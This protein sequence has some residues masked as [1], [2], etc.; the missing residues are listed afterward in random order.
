LTQSQSYFQRALTIYEKIDRDSLEV[1]SFHTNLGNVAVARGDL[2]KAQDEFEAARSLCEHKAPELLPLANSLNGLGEVAYYRGDLSLAEQY[3]RSALTIYAKQDPDSFV[4][5]SILSNLSALMIDQGHLSVA[6]TSLV[7]AL[8]IFQKHYQNKPLD[9]DAVKMADCLDNLGLLASKTHQLLIAQ[10]YYAQALDICRKQALGSPEMVDCLINLGGAAQERGQLPTAQSYYRQALGICQ[11]QA[12]ESPEAVECETGLGNVQ[13]RQ[14]R[15]GSALRAF[16]QATQIVDT[17]R[18]TIPGPDSR[19]LFLEQHADPFF[20]LLQTQLALHQEPQ[21]YQTLERHRARSLIE[22]RAEWAQPALMADVPLA[23]LQQKQ[24]LAE[25]RLI[26]SRRRLL[27][28][29]SHHP[30]DASTL[31]ARAIKLA[32]QQRQLEARI[33]QVAPHYA[34]FSYPEPLTCQQAQQALDD[35][36]LLLAYALGEQRSYL[37][38]L[39]KR[40]LQVYLLPVGAKALADEVTEFSTALRTRL[41][42]QTLAR[43]LYRQLIAPAQAQVD[44]AQRLL[45]CPDGPLHTLAFSALVTSPE[46]QPADRPVRHLIEEKPLHVVVSMSLYHDLRHTPVAA[47]GKILA[48]AAPDYS[49][50]VADSG[51]KG[52]ETSVVAV[53]GHP[54]TAHTLG[55]QGLR[56][57]PISGTTHQVETLQTLYGDRVRAYTGPEATVE[58]VRREGPEATILHLACHGLLNNGDPLASALVLSQKGQESGFLTAYDILGLHLKADL[59]MLS[60]CQ[61]GLGTQMRF[62]GVVGLTRA[63]LYAGARSVGVSLWSVEVDSTTA[64]MTRFYQCLKA[65]MH[66]DE[67]L[68]QAQIAVLRDRSHLDWHDPYFWAAFQIVGDYR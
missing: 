65:G 49:G 19:A 5:A 26:V 9:P 50:Y 40:Q 61:T 29:P 30:A 18:G 17:Q 38:A 4:R 41:N 14:K 46:N 56:L 59:V 3:F 25:Q 53:S 10:S 27:L 16:M 24:S 28:D 31:D 62:E 11:K 60:A 6:R 33:R 36:T 1:A 55:G 44:T 8:A 37:F 64:L 47:S 22:A 39:T 35:G 2:A 68:Q 48:L 15:Y 34:S 63:W 20:G 58:V 51:G 7:Q 32:V 66:K 57:E 12:P 67:A 54:D 52:A 42:Y 43:R 45:L 23:L 13:F 21:A